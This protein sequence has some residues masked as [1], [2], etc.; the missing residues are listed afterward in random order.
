MSQA[1]ALTETTSISIET[2]ASRAQGGEAECFDEIVRRIQPRLRAFLLS[3]AASDQDVDDLVQET[4]V[5]ALANLSRY[6]S[7]YRFST[8]LF[9]IAANLAVSQHRSR[10]RHGEYVDHV[11]GAGDGEREG[12]SVADPAGA[13]ADHRR[14]AELWRRAHEVLKPAHYQ[15]LWLRYAQDLSVKEIAAQTGN[16]AI[17]I[18]VLLY[19]ARRRLARDSGWISAPDSGISSTSRRETSP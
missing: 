4:F 6:D 8:W 18:R 14:G 3:R 17:H 16:S 13:I 2:L 9:T 10:R 7:R 1:V 11:H 19:R 12:L 5:K 15:V